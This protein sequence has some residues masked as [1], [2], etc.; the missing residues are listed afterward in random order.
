MFF[1][2]AFAGHA[3]VGVLH[4]R[5]FGARAEVH[6]HALIVGFVTHRRVPTHIVGDAPQRFD[7]RIGACIG[8]VRANGAGKMCSIRMRSVVIVAP[9]ARQSAG[10]LVASAREYM[11]VPYSSLMEPPTSIDPTRIHFRVSLGPIPMRVPS[12]ERIDLRRPLAPFLCGDDRA[13]CNGTLHER[14]VSQPS[15]PLRPGSVMNRP[16]RCKQ[17]SAPKV[18]A[19]HAP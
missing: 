17:E 19:G 14:P 5:S 2:R 9:S 6:R 4:H 12:D 11:P 8:P 13:R 10:R 16:P 7:R 18:D 15:Q 1:A 3:F